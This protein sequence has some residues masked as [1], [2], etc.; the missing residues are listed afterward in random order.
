MEKQ[1]LICI[2]PYN[3]KYFL[4]Q[5]FNDVPNAIK[6]ELIDEVAKI[7]EKVNAIISIGFYEDGNIYIEQR[8]EDEL[9]FDEIGSA[10]EIK[11]FQTEK[12]ELLKSLRMWYLLYRTEKGKIIKDVITLQSQGVSQ[13]ALLTRIES[14]YGTEAKAFVEILLED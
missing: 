4:E 3:H 13:E 9:A 8:S 6:E 5:N 12:K 1:M 2:S 14:V 7:A 10:L 11:R